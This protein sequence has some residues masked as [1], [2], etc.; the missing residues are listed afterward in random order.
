MIAKLLFQRLLFQRL[1]IL[2]VVRLIIYLNKL[3][4]DCIAVKTYYTDSDFYFFIISIISLI[5]PA[6]VYTLYLIGDSLVKEN[7]IDESDVCIK[8]VNGLLLIPLQIKRLN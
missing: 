1:L 5:V 3:Y 4:Q 7:Q 8:S 6:I 2:S